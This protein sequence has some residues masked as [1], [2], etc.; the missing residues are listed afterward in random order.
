MSLFPKHSCKL[1]FF[2]VIFTLLF[3]VFALCLNA[4][5]T[6]SKFWLEAGTG[7][8]LG[9][10]IHHLGSTEEGIY[11]TLGYARAHHTVTY[12]SDIVLGFEKDRWRVGLATGTQHFWE[13]RLRG[14][15]DSQWQSDKIRIAQ[16]G[17]TYV[18]FVRLG[19]LVEYDLV[20]KSRYRLSPHFRFGTFWSDTVHPDKDN[21]GWQSYWDFGVVSSI[22]FKKVAL[23][24]RPKYS[25]AVIL[26]K[27]KIPY[28]EKHNIDGVG[29]NLG[30]RFF[31]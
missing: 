12:L 9:W 7:I 17:N 13:E 25:S 27:T 29:V 6:Q 11:N 20:K 10:W 3:L 5:S 22:S 24:I 8:E 26:T 21:F 2:K 15:N 19:A 4:Q 16:S 30:I 23:I 1:Y 28:N 18:H 31:I 14:N